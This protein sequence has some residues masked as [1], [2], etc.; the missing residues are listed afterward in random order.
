MNRWLLLSITVVLTLRLFLGSAYA[1]GRER[2]TEAGSTSVLPLAE[3]WA[4]RFM[5][6]YP[7]VKV[8]YAGGGSGA[9]VSQCAAG[10]VDIGAIS[11]ELKP[12]EPK[13]KIYPIAC[14]AIAIIVHPSNPISELTTEQVAKIF[15]GEIC[16]WGDLGWADGGEIQ[17][18]TRE[19]G[20]GTRDFFEEKVMGE[21]K[22]SK[23]AGYFKSNGEIQLAVSRSPAGIGFVSLGYISGVNALS[24]KKNAQTE[25]VAPTMENCQEGTYP[26]LRCLYFLTKEAP[27]EPVKSFIDFCRSEEG[28]KI[29]ADLGFVPLV[30]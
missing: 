17:V 12:T 25:A 1:K 20:S 5:E 8:D 30:E 26:L 29:C 9:G 24:L 6:L 22:V 11:R 23:K 27:P 2:V 16:D 15:S 13:L 19:E 18:F 7:R 21:R 3:A 10:T 14:D 28:Q 4:L